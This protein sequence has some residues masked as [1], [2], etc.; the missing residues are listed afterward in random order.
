MEEVFAGDGVEAG[1]GF[2]ED[3]ELGFGH[4]CAADEDALA[5]A[6]GEEKPWSVGEVGAPDAL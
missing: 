4:Q 3:E 6:L 2:I 1:A 5:F